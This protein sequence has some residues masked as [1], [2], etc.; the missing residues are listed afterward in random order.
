MNVCTF[1]GHR[2]T[3][4]SLQDELKNKYPFIPYYIVLAY[5]PTKNF[6]NYYDINDTILAEIPD[7]TQKRFA[8]L[9]RNK[10]MISKAEYA[11]TYVCTSSGGARTTQNIIEKQMNLIYSN[12]QSKLKIFNRKNG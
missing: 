6:F 2:N 1:I 9:K 10:W 4:N 3:P 7:K 8:I 11:V 5:H 12:E